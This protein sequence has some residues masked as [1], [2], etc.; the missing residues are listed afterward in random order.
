MTEGNWTPL[1]SAG[2]RIGAGDWIKLKP[3]AG[4]TTEQKSC[5]NFANT[6]LIVSGIEKKKDKR[7]NEETLK[8][9][10]LTNVQTDIAIHWKI[11]LLPPQNS[12]F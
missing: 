3:R 9:T 10:D 8:Y 11:Y 6:H 7:Q 5:S 1:V 2:L 12:P 4:S